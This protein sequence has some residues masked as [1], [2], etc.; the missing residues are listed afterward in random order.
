M[1][2]SYRQQQLSSPWS[3][4]ADVT[5]ELRAGLR[6]SISPSVRIGEDVWIA[7]GA[8]VEGED[9]TL[10]DRS[11]VWFSAR[12]SA[13]GAPVVLHEGAHLQDNCV[14]ESE[15]G[16]PAVLGRYVSMG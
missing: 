10:A 6:A 14:L 5:S 3:G 15:P 12:I 2:L 8:I 11:S 16:Y 1:A 13:N 7:P 9:I 4:M